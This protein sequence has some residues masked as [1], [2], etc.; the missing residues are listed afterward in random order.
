LPLR[1]CI[2]NQTTGGT[3]SKQNTRITLASSRTCCATFWLHCAHRWTRPTGYKEQKGRLKAHS[4]RLPLTSY[5]FPPACMSVCCLFPDAQTRPHP[6]RPYLFPP[7]SSLNPA[8]LLPNARTFV[9]MP[10][11]EVPHAQVQA[12]VPFLVNSSNEESAGRQ[13]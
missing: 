9:T 1:T 5:R 7:A 13:L 6:Y 4:I 3:E 8:I 12:S 10:A 2:G 11:K